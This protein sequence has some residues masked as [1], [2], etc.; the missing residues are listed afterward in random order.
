MLIVN[1]KLRVTDDVDQ[2]YVRDFECDL[3]FYFSR[4]FFARTLRKLCLTS[5]N[6]RKAGC[7]RSQS[8]ELAVHPSQR[9]GCGA[10]PST[11]IIITLT[12]CRRLRVKYQT[13]A[14]HACLGFLQFG[15]VDGADIETSLLQQGASIG[16]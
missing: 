15:D 2:E 12:R 4:H 6:E 11:S 16:K 10:A 13:T 5:S 14:G 9:A 8:T 3:L 1:R 7:Q